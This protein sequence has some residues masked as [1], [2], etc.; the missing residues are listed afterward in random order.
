MSQNSLQS[1]LL[2]PNSRYA[3]DVMD[4][5]I[6]AII[7]V[8]KGRIFTILF[9]FVLSV[10]LAGI[11]V[12]KTKPQ[13]VSFTQFMIETVGTS[14]GSN[15][16]QMLVAKGKLDI[17]DLLSQVEIIKSPDTITNLIVKEKIF[18]DEESSGSPDFSDFNSLSLKQQQSIISNVQ[19]RLSV[20][21]VFGTSIVEIKYRSGDPVTA[22]NIANSLVNVYRISEHKISMDKNRNLS[23]WLSERLSD[24]KGEVRKSQLKLEEERNK[25]QTNLSGSGDARLTQ[26]ELLTE[27]LAKSQS[28]Y[29]VTQAKLDKI[30][31]LRKSNGRTDALSDITQNRLI[32]NL[33]MTE[34]SLLRKKVILSRHLGVNHPKMIAIQVELDSSRAKLVS[35]IDTILDVLENKSAIDLQSIETL[36]NQISDYRLSYQSDAESRIIIH[37]LETNVETSRALLNNFMASYLESQ[38]RLNINKNPIRVI[39]RATPPLYSSFPQKTLILG[40]GGI[41][42]LF[43]GIFIALIL[44]RIENVFQ[45]T[46]Q[47]E[48]YTSIPVYGVLPRARLGKHESVS[49]H[50][51]SNPASSLA[52]LARSLYMAIKLRDSHQ[53]SGGR[54][55]TV[56][57]TLPNEGKTTTSVWLAIT[58]AQA[59]EKVLII[60]ADMRR[61]SLHKSFGLG[62]AK[63][64]VDYLS[65]RLPLDETIYTKHVSGVH[66]MT[67]KAI[68]T[69][70]LT[71]LTSE[72]M[73]NMM[74]RLRDMYDLV[75]IDVPTSLVFSDARVV[76]KMSDK[77]LYIVEWKKTRRDIVMSSVKQFTDMNYKDL[78][79]VLSKAETKQF[80]HGKNGDLAYLYQMKKDK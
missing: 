80:I 3:V 20:Q 48:Q 76:A 73:E 29:A 42:G 41:T 17:A 8:I 25:T 21:P 32:Q 50:L 1:N 79:V 40:L 63:G 62:N 31:D 75:I 72:R 44:E 43:L 66:V 27:Q 10:L 60:D 30:N 11:Y 18:Q 71:L 34:A 77:T 55:V 58:A 64:V 5:D 4:N 19:N 45:N 54:V 14:R 16:V 74:R 38:Q 49:D 13:Y 39:T 70:A 23:K 33:K 46:K 6:A 24:L 67:G 28:D 61:P 7:N 57:S 68:P 37:D 65:D 12:V 35:E 51:L 9:C 15:I 56:T 36:K 78:A 69:H 53:K 59:G 26:I 52:E 22:A 2:D 47:I